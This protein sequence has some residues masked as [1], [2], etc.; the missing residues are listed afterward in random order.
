MRERS[1]DESF[2]AVV[3]VLQAA[4]SVVAVTHA[5][6]DGDGMGSMAGLAR[7]GRAAG[8]RVDL[9]VP[10]EVPPQYEFLFEDRPPSGA[11]QFAQLAA[12]A[13]AV[14]VLDTCSF[15]Q[16][17]QLADEIRHHSD[18]VVVI[19]HHTTRDEV[20]AVRW[21]DTS[22]A[23]CGVMVGE[24]LEALDWSLD[25]PVAEAL[26]TATM[27]D[28]GWLRFANTDPRC[29]RRV[30]TWL[31]TG[32]RVDEL[33]RRIYQSDR[34]ERVRLMGRTLESLELHCEGRLAVMSIRA[35]DF[36]TTGARPDETENVVN[37]ALR[38]GTVS[39]AVLV[40]EQDDCVRA[41]LRSRGEI[42]VAEIAK[43]FGGGG[44]VRA[45]GCRQKTDLAAFK[46]Q[47]VDACTE[48]LHA[49]E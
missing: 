37:E 27:T 30:A 38:I 7:A 48:A 35:D 1:S 34:P 20:G 44:H 21:V 22:A 28:T 18:K 13:D 10:D 26:L 29:L 43:R 5:R 33:Y 11:E 6:P 47:L 49:S 3:E 15:S 42:D 23:A 25:A 12:G 8:R 14:V 16:L 31:E 17:D 9:I 36:A 24:L 41:S 32:V 4:R 2:R 45:A 19:D 46:Q 40:V 39:A